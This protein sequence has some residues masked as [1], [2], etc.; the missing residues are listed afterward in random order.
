MQ[1]ITEQHDAGCEQLYGWP[2]IIWNFQVSKTTHILIIRNTKQKK[3]KGFYFKPEATGIR[4]L[5]ILIE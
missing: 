1:T 2:L 5:D 3:E 4:S